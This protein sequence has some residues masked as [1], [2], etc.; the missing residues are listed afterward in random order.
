LRKGLR[1]ADE[2]IALREYVEDSDVARQGEA[3]VAEILSANVC[4]ATGFLMSGDWR[5]GCRYYPSPDA[6]LC[7][8]SQ[9]VHEFPELFGAFG[10]PEMLR[11]AIEER[12]THEDGPFGPNRPLNAAL[13]AI[14]AKNAAMD[15][16]PELKRL[17]ATQ[18]H[19]GGWTTFDCFYTLGTTSLELPVHFGAPALTTAL[20]V[21]ALAPTI[22]RD[23]PHRGASSWTHTIV[24]RILAKGL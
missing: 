10:A 18:E 11:D 21:H 6:F 3:T 23:V 24:D 19:N 16:T 17:L 7:F 22:R 4:Y 12:R 20:A 14:A 8:Y 15:A 5:S 13:R 1:N 9:L 2:V